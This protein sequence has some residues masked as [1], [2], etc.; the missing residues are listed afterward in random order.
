MRLPRRWL[1][2]TAF[3]KVLQRKPARYGALLAAL[4]EQLEAPA[5]R[6]LARTLGSVVEESHSDVFQQIRY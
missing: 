2:L 4:R 3:Y 5:A 6:Q 1:G